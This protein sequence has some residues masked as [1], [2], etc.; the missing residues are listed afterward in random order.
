VESAVGTNLDELSREKVQRG[1]M[2]ED[3]WND[4]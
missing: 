2:V 1:K 4:R 3:G